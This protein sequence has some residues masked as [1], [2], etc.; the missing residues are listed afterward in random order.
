[1]ARDA[2]DFRLFDLDGTVVDVDPSYPQ[3]VFDAVGD[4]L[5][6][7]FSE[8][9]VDA[10]WYGVGGARDE[11]LARIDVNRDRFW[12]TFHAVEDP[13]T[14]AQATFVY[15]DAED[16]IP[17]L[18]GPTGI[19][20]H[21]QPYLTNPLLDYLDI[22]DWFDT[23]VCC[24]DD[25]GWKP[26]PTPVETAMG[27]LGVADTDQEGML[28]GDGPTDVGAAWNAGLDAVHVNRMDPH[29]R[30][31]CVLGDH[32]VDGFHELRP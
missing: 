4:R 12:K 32:R 21:C 11:V 24:D 8:R 25:L 9:E 22:R 18:E 6:R 26:D 20:T 7:E 5:G 28:A 2:Y 17:D 23:V 30:G 31:Q 16:Y 15:D 10:L 27:H 3:E 1:M 13:E 29:R 14:R 19:V